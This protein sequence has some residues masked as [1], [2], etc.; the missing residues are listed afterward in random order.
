MSSLAVRSWLRSA[1]PHD[2]EV[3]KNVV[4]LRTGTVGPYD[5]LYIPAGHFVC[6]EIMNKQQAV[7]LKQSLLFVADGEG[8]EAKGGKKGRAG[9]AAA[10]DKAA[11]DAPAVADISDS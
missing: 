9:K 8:G 7:G 4:E 3:L 1:T 2:I 10:A 6:E 5:A 11:A